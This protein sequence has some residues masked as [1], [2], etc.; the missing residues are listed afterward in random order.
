MLSAMR[1][2][3]RKKGVSKANSPERER[4]R[5]GGYT[6]MRFSIAYFHDLLISVDV[7]RSKIYGYIFQEFPFVLYSK[8]HNE[9]IIK[10]PNFRGRRSQEFFN[11][12]CCIV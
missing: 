5:R 6:H 10:F 9:N 11:Q 8:L 1:T 2:S 12:W 4:E 7:K 3:P